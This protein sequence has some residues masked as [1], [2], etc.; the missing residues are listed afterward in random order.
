MS[1]GSEVVV[2]PQ[3][4]DAPLFGL[5]LCLCSCSGTGDHVVLVSRC[6]CRGDASARSPTR[7]AAST[8]TRGWRFLLVRPTDHRPPTRSNFTSQ[9]L[10]SSRVGAVY[11]RTSWSLVTHCLIGR[12]FPFWTSHLLA[13]IL[14]VR[15]IILMELGMKWIVGNDVDKIFHVCIERRMK[16]IYLLCDIHILFRLEFCSVPRNLKFEKIKYLKL[17]WKE[18]E[19]F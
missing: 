19:E 5:H 12:R 4:T 3:L 8:A 2:A 10:Y 7:S 15:S 18:V 16:D 1:S 9:R 13:T 6:T 14:L 17:C 11:L